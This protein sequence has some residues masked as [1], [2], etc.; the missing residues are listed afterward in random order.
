MKRP[1]LT[2][3]EILVATAVLAVALTTGTAL[4]LAALNARTG[5]AMEREAAARI[6]ALDV[7]L[8]DPASAGWREAFAAS[9]SAQWGEESFVELVRL[10]SDA[11]EG[12]FRASA[13]WPV[14]A[15]EPIRWVVIVEI[16]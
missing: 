14:G 12:R 5:S 3:V 10:T 8:S 1:A 9:G 13:A 2:L 15:E 16:P 6:E 4:V 11:P 7:F